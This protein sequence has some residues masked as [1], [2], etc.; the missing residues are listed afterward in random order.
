MA[1]PE[2]RSFPWSLLI[3]VILLA[4]LLV[5]GLYAG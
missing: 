1:Y 4:I 2:R 5:G 3:T